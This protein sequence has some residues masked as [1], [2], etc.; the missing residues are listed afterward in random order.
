[1]R[2]LFWS[3]TFWPRIGGVENLAAKLLPALQSRGYEFAVVTWENLKNSDQIRYQDIPVYRFPFFSGRHRD[4]LGSMIENR[5]EIALL[6]QQFAPDL[7]HINSYGRSVLFH[8]N[9]TSAHPAPVLVTL[10]QV[11]P[12]E[13]VANDSLLGHLLRT[14]DWVTTCSSAVLTHARRL[15]PEVIPC[16]SVILNAL[17]PPPC[18]P[19]PISFDPPRI[20][21][22]GRLVP[23]KGFDL[24]LAAFETVLHRFPSAHLVIAGD[25]SQD[26][27]LKQQTIDLGL[28][29]C[30][31]FVGGVLPEK[32]ANLI[33][34]ATLVLIPSRLEGF[35][36]VA[37]EAGS[38]ARP[39]V[40]TCVGGLPEVIVH[41]GTGLL[42][43]QENS[44]A[45]ADAITLLLD[46]PEVAVQMGQAGRRRVRELFSWERC[47][48]AY[49]TVYQKL[50]ATKQEAISVS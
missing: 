16:S 36:L 32:V 5:R 4:G 11:L 25:G 24:A 10:H 27:I 8:V 46:H 34:Q 48:D 15:M 20:L 29:H 21:C 47:V 30:V 9:T 41:E 22:L 17:E 23:E 35:G 38:M 14:A 31:E 42:V 7:V 28:A 6:K 33:A 45:L 18:D 19:Q 2:I 3:E 40:A 50:A 43:D 49:D 37:L 1:M 26:V 13:S 39:V 12:D 44:P